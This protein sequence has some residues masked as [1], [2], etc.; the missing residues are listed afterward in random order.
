MNRALIKYVVVYGIPFIVF[1]TTLTGCITDKPSRLLLIADVAKPAGA[2]QLIHVS[3]PVGPSTGPVDENLTY[4]AGVKSSL[5][6]EH[7]Y[8]F[9]WGDGNLSWTS[10]AVASHSWKDSGIYMVRVKVRCIDVESTWSPAKIVMIGSAVV[11]RSPLNNPDQV[12][13]F[14]TPDTIEIKSAIQTIFS[15]PW[16]KHYNDFDALREWVATRI[17]YRRDYD[18]YKVADYW[19]FPVETLERGTGDCEDVAILLCS[20]LRA[21][22]VPADQVYVAIGCPSGTETYHAYLCERYSKGVWSMIEPQLDPITAAVSFTFLDWALT[23][24]YSSDLYCFNDRYFFRGPPALASGAYELNLWHSFWPLFPCA[25]AKLER[26]IQVGDKV[27]GTVMWLGSDRIIADWT[28]NISGP[29]GDLVFTWSGGDIRHSFSFLAASSGT[30]RLEIVKRDY[31][32]RNVRL[33]VDPPG[34][35]RVND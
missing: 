30:Y 8:G 33:I 19:Q 7:E 23:Y 34:W 29:Q 4:S 21:S 17:S 16:K 6:G 2:S 10:S 14:I 22:G 20:L 24:D 13:K 18:V 31:S 3:A 5:Q 12:R 25:A 1:V 28:L 27:E 9:D 11:S 35:K 32:P 26:Q 15:S